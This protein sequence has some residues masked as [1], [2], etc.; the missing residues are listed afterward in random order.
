ML[1]SQI[2]LLGILAVAGACPAFAEGHGPGNGGDTCEKRIKEIRDDIAQWIE[3]GGPVELQLPANVSESQYSAKMSKQLAR[4]IVSCQ[5]GPIHIGSVEKTCKNF[6]DSGGRSQIVC[7]ISRFMRETSESD[8]YVLTH[9]EYAGLAG[10]ESNEN[11]SSN[12]SISSQLNGYLETVEVKRLALHRVDSPSTN[13]S[14]RN[15]DQ[16]RAAFGDSTK[17]R[18]PRDR[19]LR[20]GKSWNCIMLNVNSSSNGTSILHDYFRFSKSGGYVVNGTPDGPTGPSWFSF[21]PTDLRWT[22]TNIFHAA[23]GGY[24]RVTLDGK[25]LIQEAVSAPYYLWGHLQYGDYPASI[26]DSSQDKRATSYSV[27]TTSDLP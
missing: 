7:N 23:E 5:D 14:L 26:A 10:L 6:T 9:H 4:A 22:G 19:D 15:V 1:K 8:Q 2:V 11:E 3:N 12:Y 18:A 24:I 21:T 17:T 16:I 13:V 20:Y 27:C 25:Y